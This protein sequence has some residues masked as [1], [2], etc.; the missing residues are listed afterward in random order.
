MIVTAT[1]KI[2]GKTAT[3]NQDW[4]GPNSSELATPV[5]M[6]DSARKKNR[7]HNTRTHTE[8]PNYG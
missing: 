4:G 3:S 7:E 2:G 8:R 6:H 5:A 1:G